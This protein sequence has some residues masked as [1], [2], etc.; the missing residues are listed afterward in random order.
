MRKWGNPNSNLFAGSSG[1]RRHSGLPYLPLSPPTQNV[2]SSFLCLAGEG[3]HV[4]RAEFTRRPLS[5]NC[6]DEREEREGEKD[7]PAPAAIAPQKAPVRE[8]KGVVL[9]GERARFFPLYM[10]TSK[11]V[12]ILSRR[13]PMPA[14]TESAERFSPSPSIND[15]PNSNV[16]LVTPP[17]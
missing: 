4:D 2:N 16:R 12:P 9:F 17:S 15:L 8:R 13:T 3:F 11:I 1:N 7:G 6:A 5:S 14:G 10:C